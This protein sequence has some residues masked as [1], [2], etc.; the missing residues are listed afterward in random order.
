MPRPRHPAQSTFVPTSRR[1]FLL[2]TATATTAALTLPSCRTTRQP[3]PQ[4]DKLNL[5]IIGVGG[6]G[7]DNFHGVQSEHILAICDVDS[8]HLQNA[9]KVTPDA[10]QFADYRQL[11]AL[12]NLDAV[13]ISTPDHTHYPIAAQALRRGLD[14]YC[15]KPLTHTVAQARRLRE[16]ATAH[17]CITQMGTQI[18]ANANY[19]RVVEAI[20]SGALG[21]IE[22]VH[23]FVNGTDWSGA[24]LPETKQPPDHLAW[25][26]WLGPAAVRDY[27]DAYHP[28]GWRRYW[29]FG[30]GT[31]ADMG[32]HFMDLAFWALQLDAPTLLRADGPEPDPQG[33]P[34]GMRCE[35]RFPATANRP[36]LTLYWHAGNDRSPKLAELGLEKWTNGV[37]FVGE[38]GFLISNYDTHTLGP[39]DTF[40]GWQRP[41]ETIPPSP[42]HHAEWIAACKT[43][44]QPSCW[45]G[46]ASPLTECVLLANVAYRAARGKVLAWDAAAL[47]IGDELAQKFLDAPLR[48]GFTG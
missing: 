6:R 5:G 3:R 30:G 34:R 44:T 25:D 47:R 36:A 4:T 13:V 17:S 39:A 38:R 1:T 22:E 23:V 11:L 10:R 46:Y 12:E 33:A 42:G 7:A 40:A 18:H 20:Q 9:A 27:S 45:F 14:V 24:G 32:C 26:L 37:L 31:T 21:A 35:Y 19:R 16:L 48:D 8:R 43:R 29:A 2:T 41:P 28:A 15:E